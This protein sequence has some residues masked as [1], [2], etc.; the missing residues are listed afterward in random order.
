[1]ENSTLMPLDR[2]L[3]GLMRTR[4]A[5]AGGFLLA[6]AAVGEAWVDRLLPLPF[7][8]LIGTAL[9]ILL[10]LALIAPPRRYRAWA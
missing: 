10:Y 5:L 4:G 9:L 8:L 3:L 6:A 7:G 2:G 1:M